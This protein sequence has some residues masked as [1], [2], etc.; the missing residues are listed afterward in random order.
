VNTVCFTK[1]Q[2]FV[3]LVSSLALRAAL[4]PLLALVLIAW[5]TNWECT[6]IARNKDITHSRDPDSVTADLTCLIIHVLQLLRL[7]QKTQMEM[8]VCSND[9]PNK[10]VTKITQ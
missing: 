10:P 1:K 9:R 6:L 8:N 2:T 7:H 5:P 3:P 4:I